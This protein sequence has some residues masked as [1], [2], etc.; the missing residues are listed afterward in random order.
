MIMAR[1]GCHPTNTFMLW[2]LT[3]LAIAGTPFQDC[4]VC[5]VMTD[6][7]AGAFQMGDLA[8]LGLVDEKPVHTVEVESFAAGVYEVT[9]NEWDAC[10]ADFRCQMIAG[11][12]GWGRASRPVINVSWNDAKDYV[13]WLSTKTGQSYRLLTESEWE[14]VARA[15]T[16]SVYWWGDEQ[17]A[18]CDTMVLNGANY[19]P[20]A[21]NR[22]D[23]AGTYQANLFGLYDV[24]GNVQ[25]WVEDC[26]NASYDGAPD[27]GSAW[28][29]GDCSHRI[30]RGGSWAFSGSDFIL[31]GF[32]LRSARR[33]S[34]IATHRDNRT[35]FRVARD[36][37]SIF[38]N[39]F[40]G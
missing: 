22:T 5:P 10:V 32:D 25:E 12:E 34:N 21:D 29:S 28:L 11:D 17:P 6:M 2:M 9:F 24:H 16:G 20:C 39:G 37:P 15:R 26:Y 13:A 14:Y 8:G 27:K 19:A 3:V 33:K 35:G 36:W 4:L 18:A 23:P 30:V 1:P 40:E 7:P 38:Q 31:L